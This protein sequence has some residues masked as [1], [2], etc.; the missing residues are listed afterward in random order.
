[1]DLEREK[2]ITILAKNTAVRYS[3]PTG[4]RAT[5]P[6]TSSTRPVTRTSVVRSSGP[7]DGRRVLL[8]VDA[9]EVRCRRPGLSCARP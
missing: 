9:S 4:E 6:S 3:D 8:L 2:G 1:M 7:G 5:P